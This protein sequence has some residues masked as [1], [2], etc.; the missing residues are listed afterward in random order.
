MI[1][2][3]TSLFYFMQIIVFHRFNLASSSIREFLVFK[4]S[5]DNRAT[6]ETSVIENFIRNKNCCTEFI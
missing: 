2:S 4:Y 6:I 1:N 3:T 5:L